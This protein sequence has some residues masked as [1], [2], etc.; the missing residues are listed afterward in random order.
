MRST[1]MWL[2]VVSVCLW[3]L[4]PGV[5]S[6]HDDKDDSS[7]LPPGPI[8]ERHELMETQGQQAEA[9][10]TAMND[11][12]MGVDTGVIQVEAQAIAGSAHRIPSLFPK[13]STD[14]N[15][16][17]LPVIWEK[18]PQFEQFAKDLEHDAQSLS[19]AAGSG[20]A[21]QLQGKV[22]KMMGACKACHDQFR[23]PKEK[24]KS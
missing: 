9:I 20:Q 13:G 3:A 21:E 2:A 19:N 5:V 4:V 17:A 14:P 8:R 16:R 15:S 24:S 1:A 18:W 6:A 11:A 10:N 7:K 22:Q 23:K 12:A